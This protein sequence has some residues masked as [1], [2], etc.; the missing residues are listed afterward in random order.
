M[1]IAET[2]SPAVISAKTCSCKERTMKVTYFFTDSSHTLCLDKRD[3]IYAEIEACNR[4]SRHTRDEIDREVIE[5][6]IAELK[7]SLDLLL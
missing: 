6:E 1:N 3:L 5:K 2:E 4:L 7:M